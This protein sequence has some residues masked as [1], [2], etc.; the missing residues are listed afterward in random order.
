MTTERVALV[1][2]LRLQGDVEVA[3]LA[4]A[5]EELAAFSVVV[6][7]WLVP[8]AGRRHRKN[9]LHHS[10]GISLSAGQSSGGTSCIAPSLTER[11]ITLT[12]HHLQ[13]DDIASGDE[14]E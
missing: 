2:T 11:P 4:M 10:R 3:H 6:N 14:E 7:G 1:T 9:A 13:P 12:M 5:V 8:A